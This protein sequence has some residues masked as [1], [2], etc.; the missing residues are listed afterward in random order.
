MTTPEALYERFRHTPFIFAGPCVIESE[1]LVMEVAEAAKTICEAANL[2]YVFKASFDKANR[3]SLGSFRGPGLEEGLRI[4]EKVKHT[5]DLP[6]VTDIHEPHQ[7]AP[8]SEVADILQIPAFLCRQ[9]DLLVA[10]AKTD[11]IVNIKKAQFLDGK[12]MFY[13]TQKV[14]ESGN[15]KIMLTERGTMLGL[16]R[17][18]VDMTQIVDMKELGYPVIMDVTHA[19]QRPGGGATSGGNPQYAPAL[20]RAAR[21]AGTDGF[22]FEIH[23]DPARGLS[24][25]SSMIDLETFEQ[26]MSIVVS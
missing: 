3:T 25:A 19:T 23:P 15:D 2:T 18:V 1:S 13:P 21:A 12:D 10:A 20:T 14:K 7:A 24:D 26:I 8:V 6:I 16:G 9:T 22:F 5:F 4:L 17:L 11:K